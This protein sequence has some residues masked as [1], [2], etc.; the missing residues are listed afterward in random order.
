MSK[1]VSLKSWLPMD[2]AAQ[3]LSDKLNEHV[4]Q[5][6][7]VR[8]AIDNHIILSVRLIN[9][10]MSNQG[11]AVTADQAES[12]MSNQIEY[13]KDDPFEV[14]SDE[15]PYR[16]VTSSLIEHG[17]Y[18]KKGQF[19]F[20]KG[21]LDLRWGDGKSLVLRSEY[22]KLTDGAPIEQEYTVSIYL[23][24]SDDCVYQLLALDDD[25]DFLACS[26]DDIYTANEL[27]SDSEIC[28]RMKNLNLFVEQINQPEE[29]KTINNEIASS[30]ITETT[31]RN[32]ELAIGLLTKALAD[33]AGA[34]CGTQENPNIS[35]LSELLQQY[36]PA[37]DVGSLSNKALSISTLRKRLKAGYD[38]LKN[39]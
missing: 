39:S 33:K 6:D 17:L 9:S 28:V 34:N 32:Y 20:V 38:S 10:T 36:L 1:L 27:P 37:D 12:I 23:C 24:D 4:S 8:L 2:E 29:I 5:A 35:G 13:P 11:L 7:L 21:M 22:Q 30:S 26:D 18:F 16:V 25:K 19:T 15:V 31:K 3:Y 14:N